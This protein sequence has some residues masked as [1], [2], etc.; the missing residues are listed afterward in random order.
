MKF[1]KPIMQLFSILFLLF[2]AAHPLAA[3]PAQPTLVAPADNT[4]GVDLSPALAVDVSN[5]GGLPMT[6]NFYH[7]PANAQ[8][9]S[10]IVLPDTQNYSQYFPGIYTDQTQ[11]IVNKRSEL[12]IV[13]VAHVGDIVNTA[14][15]ITQYDSADAAMSLLE[16]PDT[17]G[18]ADGIPYGILPG[19]HDL[20][21]A[22]PLLYNDYFGISRFSGRAYYAGHY[23]SDNYNNYSL[24]SAGGM[25]FIIINLQ[26]APDSSVRNWADGLLKT[27]SNRRGIVVSHS[28]LNTGITAPWT[29]EGTNIFNALNHNPNLFLMLCGHI[30]GE[31]RR[32]DTG[33][34]GNTIHT[35]LADYQSL[36]PNGGNGF[37]RIMEFDPYNNQINVTTYS[38]TLNQ[39]GTQFSLTYNMGTLLGINTNVGSGATTGIAWPAP[40]LTPLTEYE[41][42]VTVSDTSG[43]TVGPIWSFTTGTGVLVGDFTAP[44]D[45]DVDGSDLSGLIAHPNLMAVDRFAANFGTVGCP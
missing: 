5:T 35:I 20:L 34:N 33:T 39:H 9:F 36:Q 25:D 3:A 8:K 32:A 41:W 45:C 12:N 6:V 2:L 42:F 4:T 31:N 16:D 23:G 7:R 17:T 27:Y 11:W 24:I 22:S 19:N 10:I 30:H 43:T 13:Y 21:Y 37:L 38:P 29:S 18:L 28:I 14:N 40:P 15:S 26:F 44:A 1:P